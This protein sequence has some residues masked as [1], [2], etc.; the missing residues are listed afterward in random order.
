MPKRIIQLRSS[1][2]MLGA[3]RVVLE[4]SK[5][6]WEF[7]YESI[8]VAL[9]SPDDPEPELVRL[10]RAAG[11]QA[12]VLACRGRFDPTI[13]GRIRRL[14]RAERVDLLHAHGYKEN[15]YGL[16]AGTGVPTVATNHLWKRGTRSLRLYCWLDSRLIRHFDH[17]V[18]VSE[19]IRQELLQAGVPDHKLSRIANG[20]DTG[21]FRRAAAGGRRA[22]LDLPQDRLVVGMVSSLTPEKGHV[23]ALEALARLRGRFPDLLLAVVGD[24]PQRPALQAAADRLG[25]R[26]QVRFCG[27]RSDVAEV[28]GAFD[29]FL[30]P[31]LNEGLPIALL[32]AMAAARP[33]VASRVGDVPAVVRDDD[34]GLLVP[35]ADVSALAAALA[36]LAADPDLRSR[37][38][39]AAADAVER[40]FSAEQMARQY[41]LLY[42][43]LQ[44]EPVPLTA[45]GQEE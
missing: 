11:I 38:G 34:T 24:G 37:L 15:F 35:P 9:Q 14:V 20:I 10:A 45:P 39:R 1:S 8:V 33:V 42:D 30:L 43:R 3:E 22:S 28:L 17:V 32:E 21:P 27:R 23:H 19:P 26:D 29:V 36:R 41:C 6:S 2:A 40:R 5:R 44:Q 16:L 18:A 25:L 31:S 7:G 12:K 4:L 13:F